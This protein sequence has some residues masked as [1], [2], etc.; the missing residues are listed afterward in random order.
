MLYGAISFYDH[1]LNARIANNLVRP[2]VPASA[3]VF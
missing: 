2:V 3:I 1:K